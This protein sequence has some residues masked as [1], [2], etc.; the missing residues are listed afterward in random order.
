M[1]VT[2]V[3]GNVLESISDLNKNQVTFGELHVFRN[4]LNDNKILLKLC[5]ALFILVT[6]IQKEIQYLAQ[7]EF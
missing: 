6:R 3:I 2:L 4:A 5:A 1:N 7:D